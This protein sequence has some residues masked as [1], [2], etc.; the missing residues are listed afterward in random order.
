M[1]GDEL[2]NEGQTQWAHEQREQRFQSLRQLAQ[3]RQAKAGNEA[4][5][6]SAP[7]MSRT[8][9]GLGV[10]L[11]P[12][13]R[14]R[15]GRIVLAGA[16]VIVLVLAGVGAYLHAQRPSEPTMNRPPNVVRTKRFRPSQD[17]IGCVAN[18]VWSPDNVHIAVFGYA[19]NG[20]GAC[21]QSDI[22]ALA[23]SGHTPTVIGI[24]DASGTLM[25]RIQPDTAIR[26]ALGLPTPTALDAS[27]APMVRVH[28][29]IQADPESRRRAA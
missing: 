28:V 9:V 24:Y 5:A 4:T 12:R 25:S 15:R 19:G 8:A 10:S 23:V 20:Q 18:V 21:P 6:P 29:T 26:S 17:G 13:R 14:L 1:S 7:A 16:T 2:Q 22:G 11:A 3:R 27:Q